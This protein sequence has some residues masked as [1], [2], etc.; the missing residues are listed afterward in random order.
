MRTM[1]LV[2]RLGAATLAASLLACASTGISP[3]VW[4]LRP[5]DSQA[6]EVELR[7]LGPGE[8]YLQAGGQPMSGVYRQD[9]KVL[10][11]T[12]P[13]IPRF[14]GYAWNIL[15]D[16]SLVLATEADVPLTGRRLVSSTMR[17]LR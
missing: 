11:M 12:K 9:K 14:S 16:G 10:R 6:F 13:D 2:R 17:R 3:G 5:T 7:Q 1:A 15:E 4:E 8:F